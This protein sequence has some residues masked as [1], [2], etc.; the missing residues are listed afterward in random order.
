MVNGGKAVGFDPES[1]SGPALAV[2]V[3]AAV[4]VPQLLLHVYLRV[5]ARPTP[6]R[7]GALAA[8]LGLLTLATIAAIGVEAMAMSWPRTFG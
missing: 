2:I 1:F 3:W 6:L 5:Q 4:L 7:V 8:G